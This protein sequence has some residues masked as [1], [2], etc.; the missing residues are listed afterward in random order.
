M[1]VSYGSNNC[2]R[3]SRATNQEK[4]MYL[5]WAEGFISAANTRDVG[6]A[7]MAG[8]FWHRT[9]NMIWLQAYCTQYPKAGFILAAEMLRTSLGGNKPQ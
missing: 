8:I 2:E 1:V 3:F 9:A 4:Q 6:T 7:R 5:V